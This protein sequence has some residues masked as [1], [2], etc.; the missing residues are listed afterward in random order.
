MEDLHAIVGQHVQLGVLEGGEVLFVER[1][2]APGAVIN[3]TRVAGLLP[4]HAPRPGVRPPEQQEHIITRPLEVFSEKTI[5]SPTQLRSAL[6]EVRRQGYAFF[7]GQ[8]HPAAA[9]IA[10]PV[11]DTAGRVVR[12]CR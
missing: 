2:I 6:A 11:R 12:K 5:S 4:L 1:L 8:L 3:Y 7:A 9:G 10:V